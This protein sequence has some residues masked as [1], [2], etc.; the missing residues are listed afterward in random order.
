[1][2]DAYT[3][4]GDPTWEYNGDKTYVA[5]EIHY[6]PRGRIVYYGTNPIAGICYDAVV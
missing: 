4:N 3:P 5:N 6:Y 2:P 1:M